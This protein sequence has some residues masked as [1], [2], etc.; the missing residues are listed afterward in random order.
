VRRAAAQAALGPHCVADPVRRRAVDA[1]VGAARR[2]AGVDACARYG[3]VAS[4]AP[5]LSFTRA[6]V[7]RHAGGT[8]AQAALPGEPPGAPILAPHGGGGRDRAERDVG[9]G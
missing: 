4:R 7:S 8:P 3:A 2:R 9:T 1:A 5:G 6:R